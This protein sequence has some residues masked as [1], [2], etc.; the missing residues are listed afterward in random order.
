[1]TA[2]SWKPSERT[3]WVRVPP[4]EGWPPAGS[5]SCA[6]GVTEAVKRRQRGRRLCVQLR[7]HSLW[8]PT[9][10]WSG[11]ATFWR[12]SGLASGARRSRRAGHAAEGSPG[13]WETRSF[14]WS[15]G[16]G[17]GV[18]LKAVDPREV[19]RP[20]SRGEGRGAPRYRW[21]RKRAHRDER[22]GV[23]ATHST[24]EAGEPSPKGPS[25]GKGSPG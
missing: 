7:N 16:C 15:R 1:V 17:A 6:V 20:P 13:T 2:D 19:K 8:A 23:G 25:G 11:K 5:E 10:S 24:E 4:G 14:P 21:V 3:L 9:L 18:K 22:R 12:C